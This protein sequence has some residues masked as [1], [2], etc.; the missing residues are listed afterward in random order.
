MAAPI[1]SQVLGEV[2]PYLEVVK[3]NETEEMIK[4]QVTVPNVVG[5][6][7]KDAKKMLKDAG[8]EM[9]FDG[10]EQ[11][12]NSDAIIK[13]QLP[14]NGIEVYEGTKISVII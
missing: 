11:T 7:I 12:D 1:A 2:L 13:Q 8:L 9:R 10:E 4:K 6:T 14:K 3:D 5:M